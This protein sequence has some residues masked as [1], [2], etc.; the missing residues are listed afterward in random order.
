MSPPSEVK[1][2]TDAAP[3]MMP[4]VTFAVVTPVAEAIP[5]TAPPATALA[6]SH[7]SAVPIALRFIGF[8][9]ASPRLRRLRRRAR[10]VLRRIRGMIALRRKMPQ[11]Q[12]TNTPSTPAAVAGALV[13]AYQ[14]VTGRPPPGTSSYLI[15]LAQTAFET[16]GFGGGLW[17]WNLGNI[18]AGST[19]QNWVFLPGNSL[20]FRAYDSI[21]TGAISF[22]SWLNSHGCLPYADENDLTGYVNALQA[23]GYFG[24]T[25]AATYQAGMQAYL[26]KYAGLVPSGYT[27]PLLSPKMTKTLIQSAAIL[28]LCGAGVW[29]IMKAEH[30]KRSLRARA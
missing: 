1:A 18:T 15:P 17:N 11:V 20:H 16:G 6:P 25:S 29:F 27:A 9:E 8:A 3:P 7:M 30:P 21:T 2:T 19:S 4:V 28:T 12:A 26:T 10:A 22:M 23:G 5:P 24:S 13:Y 14:Q